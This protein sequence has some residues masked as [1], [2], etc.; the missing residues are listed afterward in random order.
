MRRVRPWLVVFSA[1][2]C[3]PGAVSARAAE[4]APTRVVVIK[5]DGLSPSDVERFVHQPDPRTG[6][7]QLPWIKHLFYDGGVRFD[8]FYARGMSLSMTSWAIL[9]TG[10]HGVI[11]GNWEV[12]RHTGEAMD[13]LNL[14]QFHAEAVRLRR[15]YPQSVEVLD[16]AGVPLAAD[17]FRFEERRQGIQLLRR[18]TMFFDFLDVG[19]EP[20]KGS[21]RERV[22]GLLAGIDYEEAFAAA[23]LEDLVQA[24]ADPRIRY[25]DYYNPYVDHRI[26]D[27]NDER[28]LLGA[29]REVDRVVGAA[30]EAV[31]RSGAAERTVIVVVGDHGITYDEEGRYSHGLN[32]VSRLTRRD[33]GAHNVLSRRGPLSQYSLQGSIFKPLPPVSTLTRAAEPFA[34]AARKDQATCAIDSD[35]NERLQ[36]HL[37]SPELARL[38]LLLHALRERKLDPERRAAVERAALD[39]L[40]RNRASWQ[41]EASEIREELRALEALRR[42]ALAEE[43]RL[44]RINTGDRRFV[45]RPAAAV[46]SRLRPYEGA[47][48]LNTS[49]PSTD[50]LQREREL[51]AI[52][53][54]YGRLIENYR[55]YCESLELRASIG[56]A[57]ALVR[58][59]EERLFGDRDLGSHVPA[60]ELRAYPVGLREIALDSEG[61]LDAAKTF[62][63]VDYP[64]AFT[65]LRVANTVYPEFD[66]RPVEFV[67]YR[68]PTAATADAAARSGAISRED[69]GAVTSALVIFGSERSQLLLLVQARPGGDARI[70]AVPILTVRIDSQ[71]GDVALERDAWRPGLPLRLYEDPALSVTGDRS[72]WLSAFHSDREWLDAVHRTGLGLGVPGL[73]EVFSNEYEESFARAAS[74]ETTSEGRLARRLELRR[75]R[76][77][78][79]DMFVHVAPNWN[80]N[81]MDF[82]AGG[83]HGGFSRRS[84]RSVL[85]LHGGDATRVRPGPL[86]VARAYDGLDFVPTLFEL[87][88]VTT[89][90]ALPPALLRG[91]FTPFPGRVAVEALR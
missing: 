77:M 17:A 74:R 82:N 36:I 23:T 14:F 38:Q 78:E 10:R 68:L 42:A 7:T 64:A 70:A 18:G 4:P 73:V 75:R 57:K 85:W 28:Q 54:K 61:R 26:H 41:A 19:L 25:V 91:G 43:A 9:D 6:R 66:T 76:A 21:V 30:F 63:T 12:D 72:A 90:G 40:E 59:P 39:V 81:A 46:E 87:A 49:D 32:L 65:A 86:V 53:W 69:A 56:T 1:L 83:N 33:L 45:E 48:A 3:A 34:G 35:G 79:T 89:G 31:A 84:M 37:R 80:F 71:T 44:E 11:K 13:Y 24:A 47:S 16:A 58:A 8:S 20:I 27:D 55:R 2:L 62:A 5:F 50:S 60:A 67:A 51:H 52:A 15:V 22:A 88:G 29:L